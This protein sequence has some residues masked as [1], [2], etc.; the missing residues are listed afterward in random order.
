MKTIIKYQFILNR[1]AR[2]LKSGISGGGKEMG[3]HGTLVS[4]QSISYKKPFKEG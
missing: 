1:S 3:K 2:T 4:Y